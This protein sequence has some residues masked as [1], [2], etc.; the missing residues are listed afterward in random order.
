LREKGTDRTK[1]L[2]GQVD[3]YT[4]VDVG[5]SWVM[6]DML[7]AVLTS[8]LGRASEITQQRLTIHSRYASE[9]QDWALQHSVTTPV[10]PADCKHTAH[11]F[12]LRFEHAHQRDSF[13]DHL[14][15]H[16][17]LAVFH[18]QS[19]HLSK[20]GMQ[21]GGRQGQCPVT[22]HASDCLVR[23]P[24]FNTLTALEQTQVIDAVTSF[25][26]AL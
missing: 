9:L 3:K 23:L 6:S 14:A 5:S 2:R 7:A 19:L 13:I 21:L 1:F 10:E 26:P 11:M 17:I 15:Q 12:H 16:Q 20:V 25:S 22:E 4:W 18:Y 8:Q 24:L